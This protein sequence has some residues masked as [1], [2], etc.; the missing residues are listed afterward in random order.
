MAATMKKTL[1]ISFI[2]LWGMFWYPLFA[3][4]Q[5]PVTEKPKASPPSVEEVIDT[6]DKRFN[7]ADFS[8]NFTQESTLKALE[9]TDTAK[10]K[11]WFKHPGMMRWEYDT[12]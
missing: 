11:A 12:P 5:N 2:F 3:T 10:G 4:G 8:A 6:L 1:I 7:A 9:I